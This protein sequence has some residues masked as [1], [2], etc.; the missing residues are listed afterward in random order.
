MTESKGQAAKTVSVMMV[1]VLVAK[2]SGL[3][4][5]V[6]IAGLLGTDSPEAAAF[7]F[8][9]LLPRTFLDAA[10]AAAISAGFIPVFNSYLEKKTKTEAFD[11]ARNFI[12]FVMVVSLAVSVLGVFLARFAAGVYFDADNYLA[13]SLGAEML[14]IMIFTM[15]FTSTAFALTGLLQSLG[16]FY[17]PSIMSLVSNGLIIAYLL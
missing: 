9:A 14:R 17:I 6:V 15:F 4:R 13:I 12:T 7:T 10:F 8:A 3:A 2:F 11:L 16:G 5:D 1:L